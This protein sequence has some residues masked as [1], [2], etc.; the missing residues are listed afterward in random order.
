MKAE[1]DGT[2][3]RHRLPLPGDDNAYLIGTRNTED[4]GLDYIFKFSHENRTENQKIR[5]IAEKI[6][7]ACS[8]I[9]RRV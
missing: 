9:S 8:E 1:H 6:C 5:E 3:Q 4:G 7:A 2:G